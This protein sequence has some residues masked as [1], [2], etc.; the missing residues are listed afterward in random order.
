MRTAL[1]LL[2]TLLITGC[3]KNPPQAASIEAK[4]LLRTRVAWD[5]TP[6]THYPAGRPELSLMK[7]RIPAHTTM[8]WHCH[9]APNAGYL[10]DGQIEVE[11]AAGIRV[12]LNAGD[13]L[14]EIV[15]GL[16]RGRTAEASAEILM[17]YAGARG[18]APFTPA[19]ECPQPAPK[20][21]M[22]T[23]TAG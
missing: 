6:Y 21:G 13:A 17:F 18:V 3:D 11:N 19:E 10:L 12:M 20:Q 9:L 2:T 15:G 7:I 8:D 23:P 22:A 16:H 5:Q 4:T 1:L 14:A